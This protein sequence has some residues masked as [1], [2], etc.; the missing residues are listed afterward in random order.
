MKKI[1]WGLLVALLVIFGSITPSAARASSDR[2]T[3]GEAEAVFSAG[4]SGASAIL[5]RTGGHAI[6]APGNQ[7]VA[8]RPYFDNGIHYCVL[9][10]HVI[11]LIVFDT[12]GT[13]QE[14][15]ASF[16]PLVMTFTLDGQ[17]LATKRTP[18]KAVSDP[19]FLGVDDAFFI[20]QG[21]LMSPS[22]LTTGS[23]T[24]SV[25]SFNPVNSDDNGTL[26]TKFYVDAAGTGAC[27]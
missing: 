6:G 11:A 16:E 17:T 15:S 19:S 7:E 21:R 4:P 13:Q 12:S 3:Q 23:H 24:L 2:I 22:D 18:V 20:Q 14:A 5:F 26:K 1:I 10:W 8:I 9:D 25:T 27:L